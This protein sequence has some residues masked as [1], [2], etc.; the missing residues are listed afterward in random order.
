M[1][2]SRVQV[3]PVFVGRSQFLQRFRLPFIFS[4]TFSSL[5][6]TA[7]LFLPQFEGMKD[8]QITRCAHFTEDA[9]KDQE[10]DRGDREEENREEEN[11]EE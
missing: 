11:R 10:G 4:L 6:P 2:F 8:G 9:G 1:E 5:F 3:G 7:W